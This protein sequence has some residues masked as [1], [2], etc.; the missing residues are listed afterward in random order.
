MNVSPQN[1]ERRRVARHLAPALACALIATAAGIA[2]A[3]APG[4]SLQDKLDSTQQK[5]SHAQ[6][7]AG[8]LTGQISHESAQIDSLTTQV[9][10]LRNREATTPNPFGPPKPPGGG[11]GKLRAW[12]RSI[13][14]Y[15][16]TI[17]GRRTQERDARKPRRTPE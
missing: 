15:F 1:R 6:A 3:V 14:K 4:Q 10:D 11:G 5:L 7:H 8:V 17:P 12:F 9:A 2:T 16:V 13:V